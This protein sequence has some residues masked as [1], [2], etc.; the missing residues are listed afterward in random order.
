M[1][2]RKLL[3]AG[4]MLPGMVIGFVVLSPGRMFA[5]QNA[6][7]PASKQHGPWFTDKNGDGYHDYAPDH[8]GD[9]IPNGSDPDYIR[10]GRGAGRGMGRMIPVQGTAQTEM[11]QQAVKTEAVQG[12]AQAAPVRGTWRTL[13]G[14]QGWARPEPKEHGPWFVDNNKDGYHDYAPDH[15]GDGIPNGRDP[16]YRQVRTTLGSGQ[17]KGG[18]RGYNRGGRGGGGRGRSGW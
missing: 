13:N 16:D 4:L 3:L 1:R 15:D 2:A 9:G 5:Q 17:G 12:N 8:D 18:G 14:I 6:G 11:E 10:L 7:Q